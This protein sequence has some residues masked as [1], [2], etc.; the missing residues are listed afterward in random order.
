MTLGCAGALDYRLYG[1]TVFLD[2]TTD[3]DSAAAGLELEIPYLVGGHLM[4][5]TPVEGLRLGGSL[6]A[7]R[8]ELDFEVTQPTPTD[9]ASS[10]DAI[11]W[12]ASAEYALGDLLAAAEYSRWYTSTRSEPEVFPDDDAT[13]ERAYAM[14]SYRLS[15]VFTPGV[16]YSLYYRDTDDRHGRDAYQHDVAL[17]LRFDIEEHWL[18]KLEGHYMNGTAS[19]STALNDGKNRAALAASWGTFV[20][21]TS[22]DLRE[23]IRQI[24]GFARILE[25]SPAGEL[26]RA[27]GHHLARIRDATAKMSALIDDL[28]ALSASGR[29][30]IA[31]RPI[32]LAAIARTVADELAAEAPDRQ[33][34]FV[35]VDEAQVDGDPGLMRIVFENLLRNTWKFTRKVPSPRVELGAG[36]DGGRTVYYLRD[37]GAGFDPA[38][39][40][41]LFEP[42]RRLHAQRDFEGNGV[43]LAIVQRI[44]RRHGGTIW[45]E[46]TPGQ[47][48]TFYFTLH[49]W[50]R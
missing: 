44:L 3:R 26:D 35:S 48:A 9:V 7:V 33:V 38:L 2:T 13:S 5:E 11:L 24:D 29:K 40:D 47:G 43:G 23:P 4:W 30:D 49:D 20:V 17:T 19:L 37:N 12:V 8:L 34:R 46:S 39:A 16:Y 42:F 32:D 28:L 50:R 1:G 31:L 21:K 41:R 45:A 25:D 15:D 27:Q 22:H 6:Q 14:V 18:L 36:Q 10:I